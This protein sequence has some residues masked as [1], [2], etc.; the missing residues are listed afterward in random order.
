MCRI[1]SILRHDAHMNAYQETYQNH[2]DSLVIYVV[3]NATTTL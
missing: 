1:I 3:L 2:I